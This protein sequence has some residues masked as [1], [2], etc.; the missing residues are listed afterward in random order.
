[1]S[2]SA[3]EIQK[4]ASSAAAKAKAGSSAPQI[5]AGLIAELGSS[6]CCCRFD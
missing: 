2:L 4:Q 1:M 6:E 5:T 3:Q